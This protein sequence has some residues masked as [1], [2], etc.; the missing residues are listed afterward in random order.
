MNDSSAVGHRLKRWAPGIG[1]LAAGLVTGAVVASTFTA[2][3]SSGSTTAATST[4]R[5][6]MGAPPAGQPGP[7]WNS[8]GPLRPDED[9]VTGDDAATLRANALE[10]VPGGTLYRI[11]ADDGDAAYEAHMEKADGSLVTVK[12]D[13][14]L[15]VTSVEDGMGQGDPGHGGPS[16]DGSPT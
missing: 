13:K 1:L 15:T 8:P 5:L 11:E 14:S 4:Q 7:G 16:E 2:S 9:K 10:A 6:A 12:F 3:A